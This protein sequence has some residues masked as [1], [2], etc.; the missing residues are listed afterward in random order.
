MPSCSTTWAKARALVDAPSLLVLAKAS[1]RRQPS[2]HSPSQGEP[3][4]SSDE[5]RSDATGEAK[6]ELQAARQASQALQG[7]VTSRHSPVAQMPPD[8]H[9]V[10]HMVLLV[11]T[12][13]SARQLLRVGAGCGATDAIPAA[14]PRG[15]GGAS[16]QSS[17]QLMRL[18][19]DS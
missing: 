8:V 5:A 3:A 9:A 14:P 18:P 11:G 12:G 7:L 19:P 16:P 2:G 15:S 4:S 10:R 1:V 6:S 13:H 17:P